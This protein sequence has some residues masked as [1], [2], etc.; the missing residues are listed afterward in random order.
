LVHE[1]IPLYDGITRALDE[2]IHEEEGPMPPA[3]RMAAVRGRAILDKYYSLTDDSIVYRIAMSGCYAFV[4][5]TT[6]QFS[7]FA[8]LHPRYKMTYF[9]R[10][11]WNR[12][13][14]ATAE[15]IL[16]TE[17]ALNYKPDT[18]T[19]DNTNAT[20]SKLKQHVYKQRS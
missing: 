20:V 14:I 19:K 1:V 2:R 18:P 16:R 12:D 15:S 9:H 4:V 8:V 11:K 13:W 17:W 6:N 7:S 5:M 3:I 10:A